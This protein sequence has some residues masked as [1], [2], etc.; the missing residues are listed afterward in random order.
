MLTN[1]LS[2]DDAT[3]DEVVYNLISQDGTGTRRF[4]I[5]STV[6]E[7]RGLAIKHT[8][9]GT[10]ADAIDR[11][12]V[13]FTD[14][15]LSTSGKPR[16]AIVNV[17][18]AMPRDSV[19]TAAMVHDLVANAVDLLA[20]GGFTGSGLAGTTNLAAILRGES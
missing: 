1:N 20:D 9:Q 6:S 13:Q 2:L 12:L 18:I 7:P 19:I 10:G 14:T 17:T 11:H 8:V 16:S 5:S 3:G 15:K 4:D